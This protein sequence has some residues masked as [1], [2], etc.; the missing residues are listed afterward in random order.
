MFLRTWNLTIKTPKIIFLRVTQFQKINCWNWLFVCLLRYE[1]AKLRFHIE[2]FGIISQEVPFFQQLSPEIA[3]QGC[4]WKLL[5]WKIGKFTAKCHWWNLLFKVSGLYPA[6]VL[7]VECT[8]V[9]F[10]GI[11]RYFHISYS[12]I[13]LLTAGFLNN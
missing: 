10:L 2:A 6:S 9:F 1:A 5:F 8:T 7:K 12:V 11:F 4:S 3:T 13:H